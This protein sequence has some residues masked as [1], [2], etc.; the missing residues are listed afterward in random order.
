MPRQPTALRSPAGLVLLAAAATLIL[1]ALM[2]I[3]GARSHVLPL[4]EQVLTEADWAELDQAFLANRD[5]LTGQEPEQ[6]YRELFSRIVALVPAPI[7][8]GTP[9]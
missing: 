6:E 4:A 9:R 7:G 3:E 8:L 5:P 2:S 1:G